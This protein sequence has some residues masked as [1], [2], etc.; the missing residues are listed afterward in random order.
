[1]KKAPIYTRTGD[2]GTT[3]LV[4]GTRIKKSDSRIHLYGEVD[5][6]N[7]FIGLAVS[8]LP[9]DFD[10]TFIHQIQSALFDLGSN[11]ACEKENRAKFKLPQ[12]KKELVSKIENEIDQINSTLPPLHS[13]VLP[14]GSIESSA[15]HVCRT[16]SR[17]VERLMVDFEDQNYGE[18][19]ENALILI[20]RLS[21]YF[22][23]LSR[24]LNRQ[25]NIEE[26]L[27]VPV[28]E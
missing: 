10:K 13:F 17:R 25:K 5:E 24:S 28:K 26:I 14:G 4:G 23:M 6:L 18:I 22:F 12:L 21:D 8:Y 9:K 19:P 7:S 11:M 15:F 27:W 20:N 16:V 2:D 1:M 3:G